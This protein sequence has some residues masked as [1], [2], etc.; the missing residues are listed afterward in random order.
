VNIRGDTI[1]EGGTAL[2]SKYLGI[3]AKAVDSDKLD[4][5][6]STG[7]ARKDNELG[8]VVTGTPKWIRIAEGTSRAVA[9]FIVYNAT[10]GRHDEM[11][12]RVGVSYPNTTTDH[13][14]AFTLLERHSYGSPIFTK[15]RVVRSTTDIY[16]TYYLEVYLTANVTL[17]TKMIDFYNDNYDYGWTLITP[18]DGSIPTDYEAVE[19]DL[20]TDTYFM[21]GNNI[22]EVMSITKDGAEVT[23]K[24]AVGDGDTTAYIRVG[25]NA[26]LMSKNSSWLHI[27]TVGDSDYQGVACKKL[28]VTGLANGTSAPTGYMGYTGSEVTYRTPSQ[29]LSD[30]G[31][32]ASS[33][34]H[35]ITDVSGL[36]ELLMYG[37]A[38]ATWVPCKFVGCNIGSTIPTRTYGIK[39]T[40]VSTGINSWVFWLDLPP[41]KGTKKLYISAIQI[42]LHDVDTNNYVDSIIVEGV[43]STTTTTLFAYLTDIK[44][45]GVTELDFVDNGYSVADAS[46]YYMVAVSLTLN[47]DTAGALDLAFVRLKCYYA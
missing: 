36:E 20:G 40:N 41:I 28:W 8:V 3:S 37:S 27:R 2:D 11:K 43:S 34:T 39:I 9:D 32:A 14:I 18:I 19:Y 35:S 7:F 23:N 33:H 47:L 46:S 17:N 24:L 21:V 15:I 12:F 22:G 25:S 5:I 13:N 30:I 38:N 31:A 1:Y 42:C 4:G 6:D 10:S 16:A 29:V 44:T 26:Q 45:I